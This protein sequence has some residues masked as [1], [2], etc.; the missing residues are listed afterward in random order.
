LIAG[1]LIKIEDSRRRINQAVQ[2]YDDPNGRTLLSG[3]NWNFMPVDR[4]N[5]GKQ[6]SSKR[7]NDYSYHGQEERN[8]AAADVPFKDIV[9]S[10][11]GSNQG[12]RKYQP[13]H[14]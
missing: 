5:A 9:G 1:V 4:G 6:Q 12:C 2:S 3:R 7:A 13:A 11:A 14:F 8:P 10:K